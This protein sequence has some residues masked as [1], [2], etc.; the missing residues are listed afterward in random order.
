VTTRSGEAA[1]RGADPE[2]AAAEAIRRVVEPERSG[3]TF[4]SSA[5]PAD[6]QSACPSRNRRQTTRPSGLVTRTISESAPGGSA[7]C[8]S[9]RAAR[10]TSNVPSGNGSAVASPT[11]NVMGKRRSSARRR[12]S[13]IRASLASSPTSRPAGP[14]RSTMSTGR[15]RPSLRSETRVA[16][17]QAKATTGSWGV[18]RGVPPSRR[19]PVHTMHWNGR[20]GRSLHLEPLTQ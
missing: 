4:G 19:G 18:N 3:D 20:L 16:T 10:Q 12:A 9:K 6:R 7:R 1:G 11:S 17:C 13:A 5:C 8:C 2:R 14:T 15:T